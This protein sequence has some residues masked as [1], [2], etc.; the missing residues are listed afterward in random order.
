MAVFHSEFP[1]FAIAFRRHQPSSCHFK[2]S[3][4]S[5]LNSTGRDTKYHPPGAECC[6][7]FAENS[8]LILVIT[9]KLLGLELPRGVYEARKNPRNRMRHLINH[10]FLDIVVIY[11]L[12][13]LM[14]LLFTL[15]K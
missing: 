5:L 7:I 10:F 1:I 6:Q 3:L 11:C 9:K 12:I 14:V 2:F 13:N 4:I 8:Y 15:R